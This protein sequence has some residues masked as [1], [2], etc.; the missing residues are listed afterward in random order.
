[1][2]KG[3]D[4]H[5]GAARRLAVKAAPLMPVIPHMKNAAPARQQGPRTPARTAQLPEGA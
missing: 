4:A 3:L 5:F 1:M 2:S